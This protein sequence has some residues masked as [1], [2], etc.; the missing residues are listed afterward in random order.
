MGDIMKRIEYK[1]HII[2]IKQDESPLNPR[3]EFDN[4]CKMVCYHHKYKLGDEKVNDAF[5]FTSWDELEGDIKKQED[6]VIILPLYLYD[7]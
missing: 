2:K 3:E 4:I 5:P 1:N 6:P 7:H